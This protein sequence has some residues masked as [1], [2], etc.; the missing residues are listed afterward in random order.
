MPALHPR[1]PEPEAGRDGRPLCRFLVVACLAA[2]ALLA[3]AGT[4]RTGPTT[5]DDLVYEEQAITGRLG[6]FAHELA[7]G[8]GRFHHYLHVGLTALPYGLDSL[9]ARK[10]LALAAF[11]AAIGSLSFVAARVAGRPALGFL[12]ALLCLAFYQDNWH[13]NIL[14]SYPLVFDSGLLCLAWAGYCLWRHG[15]SGRTGWLAAANILAF[16]GFCHFEAFLCYMPVLWAVIWLTGRQPRARRLRTMAL[17]SLAVPVYLAIYLAYRQLHPS[18]YAGNALALGDPL[19]VLRTIVAYSRSALPLGSF[20][21]NL[22]YVNRFPTVTTGLVLD[23][24]Q[25]LAQLAAG[26]S[27]LAPSWLALAVLTGGLAC[28]LLTAATARPRLRPLAAL[29]AV[30]AVFC[31][32][33]LIALSPKYQEPTTRG[34]DWYVTSTFSGYAVALCL[35]LAGL[36]LAGRLA[37]RPKLRRAVIGLLAVLAAATALVNASVNGAVRESKIAAASRWRAATLLARSPAL[38]AVPEGALIVAPDLFAAVNVELPGPDYWNAF[39][40]RRTG[41]HVRIIAALDPAAPPALPVFALRRLS[42]PTAEET[43]IALA[44]VTRLGPPAPDPYAKAPDAPTLFAD[45]VD[46]VTDA[47]NRFFDV[48]Y[49][50]GTAWRLA[51]AH[52][53]GRRG[54]AETALAGADLAVASLALVPAGTLAPFVPAALTL[55]FGSGFTPPERAIT[56]DIVWAGD[57]GELAVENRGQD[58][59]VALLDFTLIALA[60]VRLAATGPGLATEIPSAGLSTPVSLFLPSLPAGTSRLILCVGPSDA[61]PQGPSA[62]RFGVLG[63]TLSPAAG[64]APALP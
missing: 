34:I 36:W 16:L 47:T 44:R 26:W 58:P 14:T 21:L 22:D 8:A 55:R 19:L 3:F 49:Q 12:T 25:Y 57:C 27:R 15:L 63:A 29:T 32:N 2:V 10:A 56:G 46:I 42:A 64:T 35:A 20:H 37:G 61:A 52:A 4:L 18:E 28:H 53:V 40:A 51:P 41:R 50:E 23:F 9:P 6:A 31:P 45:R 13:H 43:S 11:L 62:K 7:A 54:L 39:L 60:P 33:F 17:A 5:S 59:A 48:L 1:A 24:A 38:D 30:Y